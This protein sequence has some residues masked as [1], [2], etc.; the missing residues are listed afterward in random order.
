MYPAA[1]H[2]EDSTVSANHFEA[3]DS[4]KIEI[5][6]MEK[7]DLCTGNARP[8]SAVS[9]PENDVSLPDKFDVSGMCIS[10]SQVFQV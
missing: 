2:A 1:I 7:K 8:L 3:S 6:D 4:F 5:T 10:H 9:L